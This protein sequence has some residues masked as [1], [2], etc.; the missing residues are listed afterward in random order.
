MNDKQ[1]ANCAIWTTPLET[2]ACN[3]NVDAPTIEYDKN[4]DGAL[5]CDDFKL[6]DDSNE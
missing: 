3:V 1:C 2:S 5:Y 6:K 4:D